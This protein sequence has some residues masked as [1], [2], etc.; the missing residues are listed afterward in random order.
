MELGYATLGTSS[1]DTVACAR[2]RDEVVHCWDLE[3]T[4]A[5]TITTF[6]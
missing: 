1:L 6:R 2:T 5:P 4:G 3:S